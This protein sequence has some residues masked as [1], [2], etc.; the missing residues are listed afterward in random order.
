[1]PPLL[2]RSYE[3]TLLDQTLQSVLRRQ[4]RYGKERRVPWG[5]SESGF[6]A[7]DYQQNYQYRLFGVPD[8]GLR[9]ELSDNL[10][11]AP[12]ATLLALPLAPLEVWQNLQRL[13]AEGGSNGYGYYEALDYTPGRHPKNQRVAV[14]RSFMAH[15]QGMSLV[16]LDNAI[17]GDVMRRRFNAEPLMAAAQLL[18]QEKLPRHAPVI[19]PHPEEGAVERAQ[20]REARDLETGAAARPFTT[21]HTRTPRTHLLSNGNYT[22]MLTNA[23][24]GYS[25]CADTAVTRWREDV[26]RDDWGT[27]IY[28]QDLDQK[29][30]W[31]A[32]HQPLR[33]EANNYEVKYL[34]DR[35]EFHRR[36]GALETTTVIAVS[37]ED[38]VEVRRIALHNAGSAARVLQL[39]SYAEVVLAQ[40][41]ADAAH[42]AFSKLF[43]E[44]EFI[45]ACR[46]LLFT[47]R[48]R[49]ADQPAPWAFHLL[50]AGYEPPHALEYETDRARFLGRGRTSADPA[51]LDATLSNTAGATLDPIMSLR[52]TVRLEP[53]ARQ[54]VT[55]VTGFAESREQAQALSDEY[56]DPRAIERAFDMV[57]AHSD[58]RQRHLGITN[59]EAHLF[60]RLASR[61]FYPDPALRA[62]SE[63]LERNRK[64]QSGLWPYGISG[65]YPLVLVSVDDQGELALVRQALLAHQFWQMHN[66]KVD[67][68]IVNSHTTSYYDAVQDAI[69]SMIDTSLSRPW[70]DQP[71]GVFVRRADHI[72]EEDI[73]LLNTVARIILDGD[74]GSLAD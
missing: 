14:V 29:L 47:R 74:L 3:R 18:L 21:P 28:I 68:V 13:K 15:H 43:V 5:I 70:L 35:A 36:D 39:T 12:Y 41:N 55:F 61:I 46:A 27:F 56:S 53:G 54:T 20:L 67:L 1:M 66:F 33:V 19:E 64:G 45:P 69:Q 22:V 51:V 42:P 25:A 2:M 49:A 23:G 40:Q 32:A 31:S 6:Y 62:P 48:P 71:G 44:S 57:A 11:I 30:C 9:R 37:P 52:T 38:N 60:Q 7:F 63:V 72:P 10:V 24:G 34:Q 50:N 8:L 26:T 73:V 59:D 17:N 65:D 16:A 58:I 4:M